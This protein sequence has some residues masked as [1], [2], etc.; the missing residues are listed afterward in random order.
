MSLDLPASIARYF[1]ADIDPNPQSVAECFS[2]NGA[3]RDKSQVH[4][5]HDE[6]RR[7]K[8]DYSKKYTARSTPLSVAHDRGRTVVTCKVEGSFPGSP[9][10]LRFFF[11][12]EGDKIGELEITP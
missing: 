3:V 7:W 9:I 2:E 5:G 10:D 12:V 1:A 11:R 6:I 4:T 8:V